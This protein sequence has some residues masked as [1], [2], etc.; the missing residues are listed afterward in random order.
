MAH[1]SA[2]AYALTCTTRAIRHFPQKIR[3]GFFLCVEGDAG[4]GVGEFAPLVG[5]H[6]ADMH[7][8][9]AIARSFDARAIAT[10]FALA[11]RHNIDELDDVFNTYPPI[12]SQV[13]SMAYFHSSTRVHASCAMIKLAALI[14]VSDPQTAIALAQAYGAQGFRH[15]KIKVGGLSVDDEIKKIR[16]IAALGGKKIHL[17]LDANRRWS[18]DE[19]CA[20]LSGL[21]RVPI[22]YFEEPT[23]ETVRIKDLHDAFKV[24]IAADESYAFVDDLEGLAASK[25]SHIIIKPG[26]FSNLF[27]TWRIVKRAQ[28]LGLRPILSHCYESEFSSAIFALMIDALSLHDDAHG[29][30][31]DGVFRH[32]VFAQPL[33]SFRGKLSV[34][35]AAL[36]S[37]TPF[38][39]ERE[40]LSR[41][42]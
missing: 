8:A 30:V 32:G 25:I 7:D 18:Y 23:Y 35:T 24:N 13:L 31:V 6:T 11:A 4:I 41:I 42:V 20:F 10:Q 22:E 17:R 16:C 37:C 27:T 2:Y 34:E 39:R 29:I 9:R 19:A 26:R 21:K 40:G 15:L 38:L 36:L 3:E 28:A 33:R 12:M 5:I 1:L 14:D